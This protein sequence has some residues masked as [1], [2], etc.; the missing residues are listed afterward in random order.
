MGCAEVTL[1]EGEHCAM[2]KH[3]SQINR[4]ATALREC[5]LL[6]DESKCLGF[7]P[8]PKCVYGEGPEEL[9]LPDLVAA[10]AVQPETLFGVRARL[11]KVAEPP[12][13]AADRCE[14]ACA[15]LLCLRCWI[16]QCPFEMQ[17]TLCGEDRVTALV[18]NR[19]RKLER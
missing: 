11:S 18:L 14:R 10:F 8:P 7:V 4:P 15:E 19:E 17:T 13:Q 12:S 5:V 9:A 1:T 6:V 3:I 2:D 16:C